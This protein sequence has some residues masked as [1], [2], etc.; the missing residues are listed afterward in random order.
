[1]KNI[2]HDIRYG[3]RMLW[4]SR[5]FTAVAVLT[6][7]LGIGANAAIFSVISSVL[8]NPYPYK[9]PDG[10]IVLRM[11]NTKRGISD[12]NVSY[13]DY[14]HFKERNKVF[15]DI[16]LVST[17]RFNLSGSG[18]QALV[19]G[20]AV[21]ASVFPIIGGQALLGRTF[22]PEQDRPG[23]EKVAVL[24]HG[25]WRRSFGADE[26]IVGQS[27]RID[28]TPHT[29]VGVVAPG[30]QF[31]DT[32]EAELFVPLAIDPAQAPRTR[33]FFALAR[34]KQGVPVESAREDMNNIARQLGQE[35]P[36]TNQNWGVQA[37]PLR[38]YRTKDA[39]TPLII[40]FGAVALVLLI[41]CVNVANLLL[42]RG[43][44][45]QQEMAV[46]TALGAS[47][48]RLI[49]QLLT[50]SMLIALLASVVG[51]LLSRGILSLVVSLIPQDELPGYLN[52]F[53]LDPKVLI[54]LLVISVVTVL[55]FGLIPA[56]RMVKPNLSE[57][58][59]EA[60]RSP[61]GGRQRQRLRKIL[62]VAEVALSL[63]LLIAAGLMVRSFQRLQNIDQGFDLK[64]T[65][66][67]EI[68]L[69]ESNYKEPQARP[70]FYQKAVET[71]QG[72]PDVKHVGAGTQPPIGDW[73]K[74]VFSSEGQSADEQKSNP[75]VDIQ[76]VAGDYFKT[77]GLNVLKGREFTGQDINTAPLVVVV[78]ESVA[79]RFWPEQD[80]V[81]KRVKV[82]AAKD[83]DKE[84]WITVVGVVRNT[85]RSLTNP[86]STLEVYAPYAQRGKTDMSLFIQT[87]SD[88]LN[89]AASIRRQLQGLEPGVAVNFRTLQTVVKDSFWAQRLLSSLF[90]L[91]A[92]IALILTAVGIYSTIAYSV[93]QRTHEIGVRMALGAP[94]RNILS[95]VLKQGM[96]LALIGI[97]IGVGGALA[98][99]RVLTSLLF[100]L[101]ST[102]T[103]TFIA[104]SS[105]LAAIVLLATFIPARLA[106]KI[107][108][109]IAL[110]NQ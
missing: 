53:A 8:L 15:E 13:A 37:M 90:G 3:S 12:L 26:K 89:L 76:T 92:L 63:M 77:M 72:L 58:L 48:G 103:A 93:A 71:M 80:A 39:W 6:L 86:N 44:A 30:A 61:S 102:D 66:A 60:G 87:Q 65:L 96:M 99:N 4:R 9:D 33:S 55:L 1:M 43:A 81:G 105:L 20:A 69:P 108:P 5:G 2:W 88:P 67:V 49:Q 47:P 28:G 85:K 40:L 19:N 7:G 42:Q 79:R 32:S 46:R 25:L 106:T 10:L 59:K 45:R 74:T 70:A 35:L 78:N 56:L 101:S 110:R 41:A 36:E 22:A 50:E 54:Y 51:L 94:P 83:K 27:I 29:V 57:T 68:S 95:L 23:G 98:L 11:A 62:V 75:Q 91:F 107:E 34:L 100:G 82:G 21:S 24:G 64:N 84:T 31:P 16:A 38:D 109:A 73:S 104:V 17:R 52:N 14:T 18:E 97:V